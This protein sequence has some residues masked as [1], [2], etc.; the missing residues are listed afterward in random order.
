[1]ASPVVRMFTILGQQVGQHRTAQRITAQKPN[2]QQHGACFGIKP[3]LR[4]IFRVHEQVRLKQQSENRQRPTGGHRAIVK[5]HVKGIAILLKRVEF[6]VVPS[7]IDRPLP[8]NPAGVSD[9]D[10]HAQG[11]Q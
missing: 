11:L 5:V 2:N 10:F 3:H 4:L 1:M 6:R 8:Q 7:H 9:P